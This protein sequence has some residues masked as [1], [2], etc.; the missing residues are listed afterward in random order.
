MRV[1]SAFDGGNAIVL[2]AS[3][4][5]AIRAHIAKD[6]EADFR[7]WFHLRVSGAD[8][9]IAVRLE[10]ARE[11]TYAQG[12]VGYRAVAST[13]R[14]RWYR[15]ETSFDDG[16]LTVRHPPAPSVWLAYFAPYSM[17]R[18]HDLVARA[19]SDPRVTLEVLGATPDGQDLDCLH[20][21]E[22]PFEAW[23]IA[24]QHPGETMAEHF[25]EGLLARLL[26]A[27]DPVARALLARMRFH[28]V[29]NMNPDGSR[30]G[31][32][33]TNARG[34]NLNRE[35]REPSLDR[36][37]EVAL[38]RA[39]MESTGVDLCLDVHGDEELPYCFIAGPDGIPSLRPAQRDALARF[40]E[41]LA[42]R[43]PDFQTAR[44]Y[45]PAAPGEADLRLATNWVAERFGCLAMTLEMP[46]KDAANHPMPDTGWSPARSAHLA[47]AC[48]DTLLAVAE[49]TP[50]GVRSPA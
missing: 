9:P 11:A 16:V 45:P 18:H 24:R 39:R 20:V 25:V 43:S 26:D 13:D 1:S 41:E 22:G 14:Q 37:P 49:A 10:N 32:L 12:F 42:R 46:F 19:A 8:A 38:V 7:Q 30:R 31:H 35:W 5:G 44:G 40:R 15:V 48:L 4:P 21:G 36:S 17:E 50:L 2:E 6:A 29:P 27:D 3:A 47:S 34:A 33:R 28:V 23:C